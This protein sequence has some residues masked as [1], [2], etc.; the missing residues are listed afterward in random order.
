MASRM[1]SLLALAVVAA[2]ALAACGGGEEFDP[3]KERSAVTSAW[4]TFFAEGTPIAGKVA[5]LQGGEK[6]RAQIQASVDSGQGKGTTVQ[7]KEVQFNEEA[8]PPTADITYDILVNGQV[9]LPNAKG[10]AVL[11][12][13]QWKMSA[14][15][16]CAL[17]ALGGATC[18]T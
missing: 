5:L 10:T 6:Y 1:R 8:D 16:Y 18:P 15:T 14:D 9:A 7:V 12:G 3:A 2:L 11:E 17:I 4:E 13:D